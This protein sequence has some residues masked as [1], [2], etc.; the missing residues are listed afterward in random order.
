[1]QNAEFQFYGRWL[2]TC[3]QRLLR[4]CSLL[5]WNTT[6]HDRNVS[7]FW[8]NLEHNVS[9][10]MK[11]EAIYYSE[12]LWRIQSLPWVHQ[13]WPLPKETPLTWSLLSPEKQ[14][15]M[16][17]FHVT[18]I[19]SCGRSKI[20]AVSKSRCSTHPR[21]SIHPHPTNTLFFSEDNQLQPQPLGGNHTVYPGDWFWNCLLVYRKHTP[22]CFCLNHVFCSVRLALPPSHF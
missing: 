21:P 16:D 10:I 19:G 11:T 4:N 3:R 12:T 2:T 18:D 9:S 20:S 22:I 14:K 5:K 17:W 6:Q 15:Q 7:K 8:T 1:M 13:I